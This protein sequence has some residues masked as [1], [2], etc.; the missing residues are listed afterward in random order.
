ME[1]QGARGSAVIS[2]LLEAGL[3]LR[4]QIILQTKEEEETASRWARQHEHDLTRQLDG[5]IYAPS[6]HTTA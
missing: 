1:V 4:R 2:D 5:A 3:P 6:H